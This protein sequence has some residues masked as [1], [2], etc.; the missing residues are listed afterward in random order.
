MSYTTR[1]HPRT[2]Q[3]AFGPHTSREV[4]PMPDPRGSRAERALGV[5][6]AVVLGVL[7]AAFLAHEFAKGY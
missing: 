6:L 7:T 2:V 1:R 5:V 4:H 3:E